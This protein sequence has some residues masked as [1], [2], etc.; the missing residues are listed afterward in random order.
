M[1]TLPKEDV[2]VNWL[3]VQKR[4]HMIL[5]DSDL[6]VLPWNTRVEAYENFVLEVSQ[7]GGFDDVTASYS[8]FCKIWKQ[9]PETKKVVLRKWLPFAKCDTC[10]KLRKRRHETR[11]RK[12]RDDL[13]KELRAHICDVRRERNSYYRRKRLAVN[14]PEEYLSIIIDGAD[15][16]DYDLPYKCT[17]S[18][19]QSGRVPVKL[20]GAIV[21]GRGTYAF[22]YL[23][24]CKGGTNATI[25]TLHR[26]LL[27]I[28]NKEG[29]LPP[30]LY[31]Q[32]DNTTRQ[33]KSRFMIG[34]L[35]WL[36]QNN[37]FDK[38]VVS[39]LP[40]GHTHEDIDHAVLLKGCQEAP[41]RGR[42]EQG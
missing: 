42:V 2:V 11:S 12:T 13:T 22:T 25:E 14:N 19:T 36:V 18:K 20:M 30:K 33:C 29:R 32:L 28:R 16:S 1:Y 23:K 15:Q 37:V 9:N 34:F 24:N 38:V 21:H 31:L 5:P 41:W 7:V 17:T 40:V 3:L 8:Y 26:V 35:A 6:I 39:F 10:C 4:Y 27:D